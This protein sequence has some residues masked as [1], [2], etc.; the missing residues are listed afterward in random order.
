MITPFERRMRKLFGV[1]EYPPLRK[2]DG[3]AHLDTD[4]DDKPGPDATNNAG[5]PAD[6]NDGS[7]VWG[8]PTRNLRVMVEQLKGPTMQKSYS[9]TLSDVVKKYGIH[10]FAKSVENGHVNVSEHELTKLIGEHAER[11]GTTFEKAFTAQ[12]EEGKTLRTAIEV[13]KYSQFAKAGTSGSKLTPLTLKPNV[14]N[15]TIDE[16][17]N[18]RKALKAIQ[19]LVA[20][21][22]RRAPELTEAGAWD[23][24][25]SNPKNATAVA[26]ERAESRG[27]LPT[28]GGR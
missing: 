23:A 13:A 8:E 21:Q 4:A 19:D 2:D 9:E 20:E 15:V 24:V 26:A 6:N 28:V 14:V 12:T 16:T 3:C 27:L 25:Y 10:A 18:P 7:S 22:K 11:N 5:A 17:N 1:K